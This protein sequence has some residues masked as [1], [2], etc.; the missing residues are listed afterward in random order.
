MKNELSHAEE[1]LKKGRK[2]IFEDWYINHSFNIEVLRRENQ[3]VFDKIRYQ[4]GVFH[5]Q[6]MIIHPSKDK[7][8]RHREAGSIAKNFVTVM[9]NGKTYVLDT[10][11][12]KPMQQD[13][14][15]KNIYDTTRGISKILLPNQTDHPTNPSLMMRFR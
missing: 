13:D 5:A 15:W 14:Y 6:I 1:I 8:L 2:A 4:K 12:G 10:F 7:I 3:G 9:E 11:V